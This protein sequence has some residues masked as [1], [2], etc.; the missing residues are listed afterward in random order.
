MSTF[1]AAGAKLRA[2]TAAGKQTI[3]VDVLLSL[4]AALISLR[5][6]GPLLRSRH[7]AWAGGVLSFAAATATMAWGT[8]HGWD[9]RSFR[10]WYL[11]G[12]LLSAPLLG[13][14]SL[15]LW[16]RRWAAPL[17]LVYAGT[18]RRH[19]RRDAGARHVRLDERAARAGSR[20]RTS[21]R[22]GDRRQLTRDT[23]SGDRRRGDDEARRLG[24]SLLLGAVAAAAAASALTQTAVG[25]AAACFALAAV[26][27]YASANLPVGSPP[28]DSPAAAPTNVSP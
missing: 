8:A 5:L 9:D 12:A 27:L 21:P 7:Y 16:G 6:A 28:L 2:S 4:A 25:A 13:I 23:R 26:L 17:G 22:R 1:T 15:S 3:A 11:A 10:V 20:R 19:R 24:N 14:G 18:C